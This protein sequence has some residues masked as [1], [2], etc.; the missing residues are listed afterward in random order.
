MIN[1]LVFLQPPFLQ[2]PV[3]AFIYDLTRVFTFDGT[4]LPYPYSRKIINEKLPQSGA[5]VISRLGMY[6]TDNSQLE[7]GNLSFNIYINKFK[8]RT[9]HDIKWTIGTTERPDQVYIFEKNC[10][11]F[12]IEAV[13]NVNPV[14]M[15]VAIRLVGWT[16]PLF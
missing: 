14:S 4:T 9:Y 11:E 13:Q 12:A 7:T 16:F 8:H 3:D 5:F 6:I 10:I 2:P 1:R 15:K